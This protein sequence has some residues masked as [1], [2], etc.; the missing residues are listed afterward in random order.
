M[1]Q[2]RKQY[3]KSLR[4]PAQLKAQEIAEKLD[5]ELWE[6]FFKHESVVK[7]KIGMKLIESMN[8]AVII[9]NKSFPELMD[10]GA[11]IDVKI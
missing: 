10:T 6:Y 8:R 3:M 1:T 5:P 9:V 7:N 4:H 11:G 2:T